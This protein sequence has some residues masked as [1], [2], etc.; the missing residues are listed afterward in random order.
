MHE[1]GSKDT[2]VLWQTEPEEGAPESAVMIEAYGD[3][4][5]I[6]C[7]GRVI[8]INYESVDE[9]C[10]LLRQIKKNHQK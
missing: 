9:L 8:N 4:I 6:T 5:S 1:K 7:E 10:K 3:V 2:W